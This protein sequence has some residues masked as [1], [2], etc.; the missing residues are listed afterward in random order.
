MPDPIDTYRQLRL[1]RCRRALVKNKFEVFMASDVQDAGTLFR[2]RILAPL[3]VNVA[4][5][6]DSMTLQAT[7]VLDTIRVDPGIRMIE[8]FD[9][10]IS[11]EERL[12][13]RRQALLS[14]LFLSGSNAVTETGLLVNLDMVGNRVAG[15]TF[16]PK[17]VVLFIGRNKIVPTL[18]DAM[19]RVRNIAAP[20]NAIRHPGL[21]TPCTKTAL[22]T[23]CSSPDR[24]CNTWC[25][26]E[27]SFP[28]GR[29]KIILINQDLGL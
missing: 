18:D 19:A 3:E 13:R 25:I 11:Q 10:T 14:D 2:E 22:C 27:K 26:T 12:E 17:T 15:I 6:G 16:G 7:G 8:T 1:E 4:S 21:K 9:T 20:A 23:D 29:I 28:A 5:W 24:I